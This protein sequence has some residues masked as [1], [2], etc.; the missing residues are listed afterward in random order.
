MHPSLQQPPSVSSSRAQPSGKMSVPTR[1]SK[2]RSTTGGA[3][4]ECFSRECVWETTCS[5]IQWQTEQPSWLLLRCPVCQG[6]FL[7]VLTALTKAKYVS[8]LSF[9][10]PCVA[11][12]HCGG[13]CHFLPKRMD[14]AAAVAALEGSRRYRSAREI[15]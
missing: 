13:N 4:I 14:G 9:T 15:F 2:L 10:T 8:A 11:G 1:A 12:G 7:A 3:S 5:N 6:M